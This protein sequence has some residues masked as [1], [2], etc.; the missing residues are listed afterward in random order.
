MVY[1]S[2]EQ[3]G[4]ELQFG[5]QGH[6]T[7]AVWTR[8]EQPGKLEFPERR[9]VRGH[10]DPFRPTKDRSRLE[11]YTDWADTQD[12]VGVVNLVLP[13]SNTRRDPPVQKLGIAL[14]VS[15]EIEQL[16]WA[17]RQNAIDPFAQH[18]RILLEVI[19]FLIN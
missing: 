6:A 1:Q 9:L 10:F 12:L 16:L 7:A 8:L 17:V 18:C 4:T 14:D 2:F 5:H 13:L 19:D 3:I 11:F 15:G